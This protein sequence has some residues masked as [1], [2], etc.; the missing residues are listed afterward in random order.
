MRGVGLWA[1]E[2]GVEET[3]D[4]V[5]SLA[6]GCRFDDC[7]HDREPGCAVQPAV[8]EGELR[9]ERLASFRKLASE[10]GRPLRERRQGGKRQSR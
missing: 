3:F 6:G 10:L 1:A 8:Q 9:Q 5:A 7:R 2:H 4:D